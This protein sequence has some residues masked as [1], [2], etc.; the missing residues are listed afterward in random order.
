M[1]TLRSVFE[2]KKI[3]LCGRCFL[4]TFKIAVRIQYAH[5]YCSAEVGA[6]STPTL[7][8]DCPMCQ[9]LKALGYAHGPLLATE[10]HRPTQLS[11]ASNKWP[12]AQASKLIYQY[13][14]AK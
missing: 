10:N 9:T 11:L 5:C 12:S 4:S 7:Q 2:V 6:G 13:G 8:A 1:V 14:N 3:V